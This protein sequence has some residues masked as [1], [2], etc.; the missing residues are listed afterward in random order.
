MVQNTR[1]EAPDV[2]SISNAAALGAWLGRT[3][4]SLR[5]AVLP[6]ERYGP[7]RAPGENAAPA[8][9]GE[10]AWIGR[11][12]RALPRLALIAAAAM[13]V[14]AI[15]L[16]AFRAAYADKVY[17]AVAVGDV[18]VGGMTVD[19][20]AAAVEERAEAM[21]QGTI[22]FTY[23]GQTW[24]PTLSEI[25]ASVD[26]DT[27]VD[28]AWELGR[29]DN[30]VMRLGFA[31]DLLRGD[32]RVP[33]R[34]TVDRARLA[35]WFA[36]VNADIDQ[37]AVDASLVVDGGEVTI[38]PEHNGIVVDEAAATDLVLGA[39]DELEP[40]STTLPT[41]T[42]LPK[43]HA[44]ELAGPRDD[45]AAALGTPVVVTFDDEK[46]EID[47]ADLTGFL[48][49]ETTAG[50]NGPS[51]DLAFDRN[52]LANYLRD[53]FSGDVNRSPVD[54]RI[55]WSAE[56]GGLVSLDKSVNGA[57]LRSTAFADAVAESFLG[58]RGPVE[59]PVVL[60]KPAV[61]SNN[62]AALGI[63]GLLSRGDSNF[64]GGS[65]TR[66]NNIYVGV[67]LL[68]GELVAPGEEFS[69]NH[70]VGEITYDKGFTDAGV[71][72][73]GI[74]G[75]DVGGGICQ[76][77]TTVFRAALL[78]GMP[79]TEWTWH[80]MRL[81]GYERDGW[82]A[83]FDASILQS[84]SDPAYWGDFK[85]KNETDGYMLVQSWT[86]Y[87]YVIVEIY[88]NDDGRTVSLSDTQIGQSGDAVVAWFTRVVT[89]A[90]GT[91]SE[92]TFESYY[93]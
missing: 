92:R 75:R 6:E 34:T 62:L 57:A 39:L 70:A 8:A 12:G 38:S 50:D 51:V 80:S 86:E 1:M 20:A 49:V 47:P 72:E 13:L 89:Y 31:N 22:T 45:L 87:P 4:R 55:A 3:G 2:A 44:D 7:L 59:V 10:R 56:K 25:G 88:G 15:A 68:N 64:A 93:T 63:D 19:Q 46:W 76:V 35:S 17:P 33:L 58:D 42:E 37:R 83:G 91:T 9:T 78:S 28:T 30:A 84:G 60:T 85:F 11:L 26:V 27:S 14:V 79:I 43:I 32:Q 52:A 40:V 21:E 48:T 69:F 65:E 41:K 54:A 36:S 24:S 73:N 90:D 77:S 67:D 61:D 18:N 53:T 23:Q 71:I 74:I 16:F 5:D 66:D 81:S 29:S 82:S